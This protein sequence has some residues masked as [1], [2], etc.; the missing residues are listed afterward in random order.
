MT[1]ILQDVLIAAI[2]QEFEKFNE[3]FN[4]SMDS[5]SKYRPA[6]TEKQEQRYDMLMKA[7]VTLKGRDRVEK[8]ISEGHL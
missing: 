6:L 8:S 5:A 7:F 2:L 1:E 4:D 3:S